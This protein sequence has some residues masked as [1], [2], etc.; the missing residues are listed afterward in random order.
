MG[1]WSW[2]KGTKQR[3]SHPQDSLDA[4]RCLAIMARAHQGWRLE[5]QVGAG[6]RAASNAKLGSWHS[7]LWG[8]PQAGRSLKS[9]VWSVE[10][11]AQEPSVEAHGVQDVRPAVPC[12]THWCPEDLGGEPEAWWG[13]LEASREEQIPALHL[14]CVAL[15][16]GASVSSSA[17]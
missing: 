2:G 13:G 12:S 15:G 1:V 11:L 3:R 7:K 6:V 9:V 8:M 5:K 10:G 16:N 14:P 4:S 17:K